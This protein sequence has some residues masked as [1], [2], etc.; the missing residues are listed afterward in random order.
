MRR[1]LSR[2]LRNTADAMLG[3]GFAAWKRFTTT[4]GALHKQSLVWTVR[5]LLDGSFASNL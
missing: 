4:A 1:V 5:G 2:A 3:R